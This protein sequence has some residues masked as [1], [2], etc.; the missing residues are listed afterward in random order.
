MQLIQTNH[1]RPALQRELIEILPRRLVEAIASCGAPC[2]E[3]LRLSTARKT[4]VTA[5][6]KSY[7]TDAVLTARELSDILLQM[8]G[9]SLYAYADT[10][11]QGYLC[12]GGGIRVGVAGSAATEGE[13][14]IGV[15]DVTSLII[16][17][18]HAR[19][20]DVAPLAERLRTPN[21][22]GGAL[23]Y[24][25][26]GEGK[27]TLLRLLAGLLSAS[28]YFYRTVLVDTRGEL[29]FSLDGESLNLSILIGYPRDVGIGIAVRSLGAQ[30]VLCDEI[31][32]AKDAEAILSAANCGVPLI[33]STH[34]R[35]LA[36]LLRRPALSQ[37]HHARAFDFYVGI[38]RCA[39]GWDYRIDPWEECGL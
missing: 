11:R 37:L 20:F 5:N 33:A 19:R 38:K 29:Q 18:P 24:A 10:L 13:R 39:G 30:V 1:P 6:G 8:C 9:G 34:A 16:R 15:N 23:I 21:G 26:P 28:G 3:E 17:I 14:I 2:A 27:T 32:G 7:P 36:E 22:Q 25:P 31:G 35:T 4:F 12:I